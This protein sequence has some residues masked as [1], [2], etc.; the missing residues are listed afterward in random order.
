[1]HHLR[2]ASAAQLLINEFS[3]RWGC[4]LEL[5]GEA[6]AWL[7]LG[8]II[9]Q[10]P[11][12]RTSHAPIQ[13]PHVA[14][15][16]DPPV[17]PLAPVRWRN[18]AGVWSLRGQPGLPLGG[19]GPATTEDRAGT[20]SWQVTW[21]FPFHTT[22]AA[23]TARTGFSGEPSMFCILTVRPELR[24]SGAGHVGS[25]SGRSR[26]PLEADPPRGWGATGPE[27]QKSGAVSW[28][29]GFSFYKNTLRKG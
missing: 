5:Q 25:H 21:D 12:Q 8:N 13:R 17:A 22:A 2:L 14:S 10:H 3:K 23:A 27:L 20:S 26:G 28:N 29:Q 6:E 18:A 4:F 7:G 11:P 9:P 19:S 24:D 15:W 16:A 1:M